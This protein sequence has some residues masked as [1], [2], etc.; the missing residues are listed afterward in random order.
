MYKLIICFASVI[1]LTSYKYSLSQI[2]WTEKQ[3]GTTETIN[4]LSFYGSNYGFYCGTNGVIGKTTDYGSNWGIL[5]TPTTNNLH[6]I[7]FLNWNTGW[8]SGGYIDVNTWGYSVILKT[9]NGGTSWFVQLSEPTDYYFPVCLYFQNE[10]YGF[11]ACMGNNGGGTKGGILKTTNGGTNWTMISGTKPA[12]KI[13][14]TDTY[15]AYYISKVWEDYNNIDTA[16]VFKSNNG[17]QTWNPVFSKQFHTFKNIVF[18]NANTGFVQADSS[19]SNFTSYYKTTNAGNSWFLTSSGNTGH[20][21]SY[22]TNDS[23]GWAVGNQILKTENGG[24]NWVAQPVIPS[25]NLRSIYFIDYYNGWSGGSNGALYNAEFKDTTTGDFFPLQIGNKFVYDYHWSA[26]WPGGGNSSGSG[27]NVMSITDTATFNGRK[28][29]YCSGNFSIVQGWV[30]VDTVTKSL[31]KYD[32]AGTCQYYNHETLVDSLGMK[33]P[34][35]ENSCHAYYCY[36]YGPEVFW[37]RSCYQIHFSKLNLVNGILAGETHRYYN[38][39]F[40]FKYYTSSYSYGS[41]GGSDSYFLAGS[42]LNGVVYGDT[43]VSVV[44]IKDSSVKEPDSYSLEQNYPN[45]FNPVTNIRFSLPEK[46]IVTLK[47]Y[48]MAGQLV[49]TLVNNELLDAGT[50][51]RFFNANGLASGIYFYSLQTE[52]FTQT[53]RMVLIK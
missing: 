35:M 29:F 9:T 42:I 39:L 2:V 17:G 36:G 25:S 52:K 15:T 21:N 16:I 49:K 7:H 13:V 6:A 30:R 41:S 38:K 40:G 11:A 18:V 14:F 22:F 28:Y 33:R 23:M 47:V 27:K 10:Y 48:N 51:L 45:P 32:S 34:G 26:H 43:S 12:T 31:Y 3:S 46:S 19:Y 1:L 37:G 8:A 4:A 20:S 5:K 50:H 53:K 44:S 24:A